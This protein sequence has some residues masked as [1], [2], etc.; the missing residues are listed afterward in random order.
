MHSANMQYQKDTVII[1]GLQEEWKR[2]TGWI[3]FSAGGQ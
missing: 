2:I 1:A 3:G